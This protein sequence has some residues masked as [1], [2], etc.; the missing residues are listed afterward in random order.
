MPNVFDQ[1]DASASS[2]PESKQGNVFDQFD[3]SGNNASFDSQQSQSQ[4]PNGNGA[5]GDFMAGVDQFNRAFGRVAEG[6]IAMLSDVVGATATKK[7]VINFQKQRELEAAR[8]AKYHPIS[9]GVG[10]VLGEGAKWATY[11]G[12]S[13]ISGNILASSAKIAIQQGLL[14]AT[15][16]PA[17]ATGEEKLLSGVD[18]ATTGALITGGA[19]SVGLLAKKSL[20]AL[21]SVYNKAGGT[22]GIIKKGKKIGTGL[23]ILGGITNLF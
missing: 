4:D 7:S 22:P 10:Q 13:S 19:K 23:G 18:A 6:T 12:P 11:G 21:Q 17:D 1:F 14:G 20:P 15:S 8:S 16:T 5:F 9:A 3:S 2:S